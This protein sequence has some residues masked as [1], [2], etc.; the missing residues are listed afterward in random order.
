MT[1]I[2]ILKYEVLPKNLIS[3]KGI[4]ELRFTNSIENK[5]A[6][7]KLYCQPTFHIPIFIGTSPEMPTHRPK[8]AKECNLATAFVNFTNLYY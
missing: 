5:S 1:R 2:K 6:V 8:F 3:Y 4:G 7:S